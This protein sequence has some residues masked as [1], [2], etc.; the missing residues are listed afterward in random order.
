[1]KRFWL[2]SLVALTIVSLSACDAF[3][4]ALNE[5]PPTPTPPPARPLSG[6]LPT[7]SARV[8]PGAPPP[9][10]PG[11]A[12][13]PES[14]PIATIQ[15]LETSESRTADLIRIWSARY[16]PDGSRIVTASTDKTVRV[17]DAA[18]GK[19]LLVLRGHPGMVRDAVYSPDGAHILSYSRAGARVWDAATGQQLY[20]L[21]AQSNSIEGAQFSP[22]GKQVL[23]WGQDSFDWSART[24]E[25][26]T[27]KP[28]LML[29]GH[30]GP[31]FEASFSPDGTR[32][33]TAGN[34]G[35]ARLWDAATGAS[36]AVLKGHSGP[37]WHAVYSPDG[38][39]L[40][41]ASQDGTAR[42]W[43][44]VEGRE[45]VVL[46]G[47]S[48]SVWHAAWSPDGARVATVSDDLTGR[49]WDVASGRGL[50]VLRW[51][52]RDLTDVTFSPDGKE[53]VV[54]ST[55]DDTARVYEVESG[56]ELFAL[57]AE[58]APS[59]KAPVDSVV[60]SRDGTRI[61]TGH[62][63]TTARVWDAASGQ[64]LLVL[65]PAES[66]PAPANQGASGVSASN[67]RV[68]L[69][70]PFDTIGN[71]WTVDS[72]STAQ[73]K[74]G[75]AIVGGKYIWTLRADAPFVTRDIP[76]GNIPD[77]QATS[78]EGRLVSG[79]AGCGYGVTVRDDYHS[80]YLMTVNDEG[81]WRFGW[82][83]TYL[84][85]T[86]LAEGISP[87]I[88]P[89]KVNQVQVI[90]QGD[91]FKLIVNGEQ[92]GQVKDSTLKGKSPGI[93]VEL[94]NAGDVCVFE[95]DNFELRAPP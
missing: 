2:I 71:D 76:S 66:V 50:Q 88:Q 49:V 10:A 63:D 64:A 1:M 72:F 18:T 85:L 58:N 65:R 57:H 92:V 23:T 79:P 82:A 41:T 31:I 59:P 93:G 24:W 73:G 3:T 16:S 35:T 40:V 37:I 47:H 43:D 95:F 56:R 69:S 81:A 29:S 44:A 70:D 22:D 45:L 89:G 7:R 12:A 27:G 52:G 91:Q 32:V 61:L 21:P 26:A 90:A 83:Q 60:F 75:K 84:P 68:I 46:H 33:M 51:Q 17:W 11:T 9:S 48:D 77:D 30:A 8:T 28:L 53:L 6:A 13:P 80:F 14:D 4:T 19:E 55:K 36:I 67:W 34:D 39:R 62:G 38:S 94:V 54:S 86:V 20:V 5:L 42:L 78:V 15:A 25:A 87:A 74:V